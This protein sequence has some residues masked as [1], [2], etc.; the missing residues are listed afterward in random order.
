MFWNEENLLVARCKDEDTQCMLCNMS[1]DKYY[2]AHT[3]QQQER[4]Y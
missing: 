3:D 1:F 2:R 4:L